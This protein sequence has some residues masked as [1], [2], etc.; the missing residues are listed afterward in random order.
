MSLNINNNK[1]NGEEVR[2]AIKNNNARAL[3]NIKVE[4]LKILYPYLKTIF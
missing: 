3:L 1:P 2:K 4:L